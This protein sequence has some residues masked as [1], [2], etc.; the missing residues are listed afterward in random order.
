MLLNHWPTAARF[1][2]WDTFRKQLKDIYVMPLCPKSSNLRGEKFLGMGASVPGIYPC[3]ESLL[4]IYADAHH[5]D[6]SFVPHVKSWPLE[7]AE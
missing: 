1:S 5:G 6:I 3:E 7:Q 4:A 2:T